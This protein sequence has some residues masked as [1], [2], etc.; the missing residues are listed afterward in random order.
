ME[1]MRI[2]KHVSMFAMAS[3]LFAPVANTQ[4]PQP[5]QTTGSEQHSTPGQLV[6]AFNAVFGKQGPGV[7][8]NHAK[9]VDLEG[10]FLPSASAPCKNLR[11]SRSSPPKARSCRR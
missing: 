6:D 4:A 9:G 2:L 11:L 8:A 10:V 3:F 7:R 1:R 5:T